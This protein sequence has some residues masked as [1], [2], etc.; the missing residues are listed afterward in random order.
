MYPSG[1]SLIES[2]AGETP[3]PLKISAAFGNI[4]TRSLREKV[5]SVS[6]PDEGPAR[7]R[8][9]EDS[10]DLAGGTTLTLPL[11]RVPPSP[12]VRERGFQAPLSKRA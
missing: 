6:E 8:R 4:F 11:T 7:Q 5:A 3:A 9:S 1:F 2:G 12:A 10:S